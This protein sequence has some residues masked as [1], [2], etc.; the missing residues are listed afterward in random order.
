M[1]PSQMPGYIYQKAFGTRSFFYVGGTRKGELGKQY[2]D[3]QMFVEVYLPEEIRQ[4]YPIIFFHGAGQT[5]INWLITP[6][7]R[8]GWADYFVEQGYTVYLAEQPS[9]GR[10]AYHY[11]P[12]NPLIYHDLEDLRERFTSDQGSWPQAAKHDQWPGFGEEDEKAIFEQFARSQ[13]EYLPDNKR[14]QELVLACMEELLSITGPAILLTHSQAGPF[15]WNTLDRY[16]EMVKGI[17][18]LEPSGPPF[19]KSLSKPVALNYGISELPLHF[20]P[21]IEKPENFKLEL[22]PAPEKGLSDGWIMKADH[23][24]PHFTGK[25]ILLLVSEASYHAQFDHLTSAFLTQAGVSHDFVRLEQKG[26]CGNGHMMMLEKNNWK[27]ASLIHN[28]LEAKVR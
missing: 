10:S 9:R 7:G 27:I 16:P 28:W 17:V 1:K 12:D 21:E 13:V 24:L 11:T 20:L 3:G 26:I 8:K 23:K 4:P 18:A 22:L 15:G 19:S 6:D 25:P 5:N 14:S 2:M